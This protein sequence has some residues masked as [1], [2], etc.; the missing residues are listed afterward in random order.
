MVRLHDMVF[1]GNNKLKKG[2]EKMKVIRYI[3][4]DFP[5]WNCERCLT[6]KEYELEMQLNKKYH[7]DIVKN[8]S[9]AIVRLNR[10]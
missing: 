3:Y 6:E 2:D 9:G 5:A 7:K 10:Y 8:A 1:S 4:R